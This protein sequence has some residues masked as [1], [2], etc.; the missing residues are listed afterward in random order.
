[1]AHHRCPSFI[2]ANPGYTCI[3][4][5]FE[6]NEHD[7]NRR[8]TGN[9]VEREIIGWMMRSETEDVDFT[10]NVYCSIPILC[11][12]GTLSEPEDCYVKDTSGWITQCLTN[13]IDGS[14]PTFTKMSE[15]VDHIEDQLEM[16]KG[17]GEDEDEENEVVQ[18]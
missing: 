17:G 8:F 5:I 18:H 2:P 13:T 1:M 12:Y 7:N 10:H 14:T 9:F 16:E 4:P 15:L 3:I 6:Y 11:N